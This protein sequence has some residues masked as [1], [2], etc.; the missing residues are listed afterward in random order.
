[1]TQNKVTENSF[2]GVALETLTPELAEKYLMGRAQTRK[3]KTSEKHVTALAKDIQASRWVFSGD[4]I[5]FDTDGHMVDGHARCMAVI[6]TGT[7]IPVL[8]V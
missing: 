6:K 7:P 3:H 4:T 5:R 2:D 1:M 8:K